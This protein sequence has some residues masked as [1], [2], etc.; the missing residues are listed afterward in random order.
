MGL[1]KGLQFVRVST[2]NMSG[3]LYVSSYSAGQRPEPLQPPF[4]RDLPTKGSTHRILGSI[5]HE[6]INTAE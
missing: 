6:N 3:F 4:F 1:T 2:L 5:Y